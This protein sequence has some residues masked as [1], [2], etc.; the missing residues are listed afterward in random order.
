MIKKAPH[1]NFGLLHPVFYARALNLFQAWQGAGID[2]TIID[3]ARSFVAQ[4]R[5]Y[6]SGKKGVVPPSQSYHVKLRAIDASFG[7]KEMREKARKIA[8][9][10]GLYVID[11]DWAGYDH[12]HIDDRFFNYSG[13]K[14][15]K[16]KKSL[17]TPALIT[18]G[19]LILFFLIGG[20]D[21]LTQKPGIA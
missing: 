8:R 7:S 9:E 14:N 20:K 21:D 13:Q 2:F 10:R 4:K 1:V 5:A 6:E 19:V 3:G 11:E 12:L 16:P 17:L 15:P 18:A